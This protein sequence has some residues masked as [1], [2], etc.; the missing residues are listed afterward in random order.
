MVVVSESSPAYAVISRLATRMDPF[1]F[2]MAVPEPPGT[3]QRGIYVD[4]I[5]F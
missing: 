2:R 5:Y 3:K 4:A 1:S